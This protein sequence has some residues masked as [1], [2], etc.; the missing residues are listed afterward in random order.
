MT[1]IQNEKDNMNIK[2]EEEFLIESELNIFHSSEE[3]KSG[4]LEFGKKK[5]QRG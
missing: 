3:K 2:S 1:G 4:N 5:K